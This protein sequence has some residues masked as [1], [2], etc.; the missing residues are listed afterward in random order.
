MRAIISRRLVLAAALS[1]ALAACQPAPI[2][3]PERA[4]VILISIDGFRWDYL[5]RYAPPNLLKLAAEGVRADGLIPQFPSKTFPNHYTIVTGLTLAHHGIVSNNMTAP[6]IPGEFSLSNREVQND[7]RWWGGEPIWNTAER[8]GRKSA[9]MF[10]PGSE[11]VIGGR[12]G[13]YWTPYEDGMPHAERLKRLL[14]WLQLP[15]AERP[16]FLTLYFSDV[17]TAGHRFGPEAEETRAA[18]A[19]VDQSI[20]ELVAGVRRAGL[21]DR[22][23]YVIV[24]DHGM[25]ALSTDRTIVL[26]DYVDVA[27]VDVIDW[28]P[29]LG[30]N[31]LDGDHEKLYRALKDKHP[32]LTVYRRSEIPERYGLAN[33]PRVPA[34]FG[35][36]KDGWQIASK[37]DVGRWSEHDRRPPGG[38]HGYDVSE[39]SMQGLFVATGPRIRAGMRVKP[40]ENLHLYEFMC[41]ILGLQ[42]AKNDGDPAATRDMLR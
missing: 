10:W 29:M 22:V 18:V 9:A 35:V 26:D 32:A 37:R 42:P 6:D 4:I 16:A 33:H 11:V 39:Q 28:S 19:K 20:G 8:Q 23:H 7:P 12:R 36:A 5:D 34:V 17:D 2:V 3:P 38:A 15:E 13:T 25:S 24:S 27:T 40:I 21:A 31:A 30:V 14:S 1:V 41:A